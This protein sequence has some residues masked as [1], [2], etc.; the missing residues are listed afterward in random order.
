MQSGNHAN[1]LKAMAHEIIVA[2]VN[3]LLPPNSVIEVI[4]NA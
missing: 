1:P 2:V 3:A 4:V